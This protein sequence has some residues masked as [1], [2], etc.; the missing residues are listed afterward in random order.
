MFSHL[1]MRIS[2]NY[3]ASLNKYNPVSC[4]IYSSSLLF[5][6]SFPFFPFTLFVSVYIHSLSLSSLSPFSPYTTARFLYYSSASFL[7]PLSLDSIHFSL[8]PT[9]NPSFLISPLPVAYLARAVL[10]AISSEEKLLKSQQSQSDSAKK[11]D[12][13]TSEGKGLR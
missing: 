1:S 6:S 13:E 5:S 3:I 2:T 12:K 10:T 8:K 7:V 9:I 11:T 4:L